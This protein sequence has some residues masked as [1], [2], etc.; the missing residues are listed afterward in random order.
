MRER[1]EHTSTVSNPTTVD[2]K[3]GAHQASKRK[4]KLSRKEM[5]KQASFRNDGLLAVSFCLASFIRP[6]IYQGQKMFR[7]NVCKHI[8]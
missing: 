6:I 3:Q 8:N 4:I 2:H 7:L 1:T 5:A